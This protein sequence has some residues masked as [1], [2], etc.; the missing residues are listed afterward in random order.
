MNTGNIFDQDGKYINV[1]HPTY[2]ASAAI[3]TEEQR[4]QI[5][6]LIKEGYYPHHTA[7][8]VGNSTNK[9]WNIEDYKGRYGTGK[10]L[11]TTSTISKKF[12]HITYFIQIV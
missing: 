11:I 6:Q 4:K 1:L 9:H 7:I 5:K 10:K 8:G 3:Y 2:V 12:N